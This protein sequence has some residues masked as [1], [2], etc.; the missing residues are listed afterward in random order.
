[1]KNGAGASRAGGP[2]DRWLEL[3][4]ALRSVV[5]VTVSVP[6]V[7]VLVVTCF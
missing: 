2:L 1:V 3:L 5:V 6:I 4:Q 7:S